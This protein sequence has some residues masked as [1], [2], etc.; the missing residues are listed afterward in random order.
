MVHQA[1]SLWRTDRPPGN[2][3]GEN[4]E[5]RFS[6]AEFKA[7]L[8]GWLQFLEKPQNVETR[9]EVQLPET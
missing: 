8:Q 9:V 1:A 3:K 5:G 2:R 6:L 4:K 7:A